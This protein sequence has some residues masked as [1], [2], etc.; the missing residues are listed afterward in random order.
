MKTS[1]SCLV[2]CHGS[3]RSSLRFL[4]LV[5]E[6]FICKV[7]NLQL[8]KPIVHVEE[9]YLKISLL[10]EQGVSLLS[11]KAMHSL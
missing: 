5:L 7:T 8:V 2:V 1:A 3:I 9:R 10:Q 6:N 4:C 11:Q